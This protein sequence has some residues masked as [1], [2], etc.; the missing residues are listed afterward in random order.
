[1]TEYNPGVATVSHHETE[2]ILG[3]LRVLIA[4]RGDAHRAIEDHAGF[5]P[6][7]LSQLL[8]GH[9]DLKLEHLF[10]ILA[11]IEH[12][13]SQLFR[14]LY[15]EHAPAVVR[16]EREGLTV[17]E[18]RD[19]ASVFGLG[20]ASLAHLRT[21]LERCEDVLTDLQDDLETD[22]DPNPRAR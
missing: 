16:H 1:M 12:P 5:S 20:I 2:R 4:D 13:P 11:A 6:G 9:I 22:D 17:P 18:D 14:S 21:R 15:G 3:Q 7:Y 8:G 10:A 19:L